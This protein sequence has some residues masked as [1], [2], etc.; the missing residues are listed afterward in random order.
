MDENSNSGKVASVSPIRSEISQVRQMDQVYE[1][2]P[3][4]GG[5]RPSDFEE[6]KRAYEI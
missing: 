3:T 5:S 2:Q 4:Q 1:E 6:N